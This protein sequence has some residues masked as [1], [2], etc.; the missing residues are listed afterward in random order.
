MSERRYSDEDVQRILAN[1]AESEAALGSN[2]SDDRGMTLAE[3]QRIAAEAGLSPASVRAAAAALDRAPR[4]LPEP[5]VLG[6]RAGVA[7]SV[8]LP[9]DLTDTEWQRLVACFRDTFEAQGRI[10]EVAGRREWRNGNLRISLESLGEDALLQM[11]TRKEDARSMIQLGATMAVG[12]LVMAAVTAVASDNPQ[13]LAGILT[14]AL[15]GGA[16]GISGALRLPGWS[17]TRRKQFEA[18]GEYARRLSA[19]GD[20]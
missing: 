16:M 5:R 12:G 10:E 6:L 19:G 3:I 17:A 7:H 9:R 4:P 14:I 11:R 15:G 8:P 1:A 18:V 13:A 20:G 2:G